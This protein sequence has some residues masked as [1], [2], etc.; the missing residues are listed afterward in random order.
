MIGDRRREWRSLAILGQR[1][2]RLFKCLDIKKS[3]PQI[4][5]EFANNIDHA[6]C[7]G[8]RA[9]N[10]R[11]RKCSTE[12]KL[13][14]FNNSPRKT[15]ANHLTVSTRFASCRDKYVR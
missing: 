5:V 8:I 1:G 12:V 10:R 6:P 15:G 4:R 2:D 13:P 11:W 7:K 9:K 14:R 3:P